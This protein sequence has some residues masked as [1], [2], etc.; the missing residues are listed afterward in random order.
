MSQKGE[1]RGGSG[2]SRTP[3]RS[4]LPPQ[5]ATPYSQTPCTKPRQR[6]AP[7]RPGS[8][9]GPWPPPR[10]CANW[11]CA[12]TSAAESSGR[13][14]APLR[15]LAA[16]RCPCRLLRRRRHGIGA[17]PCVAAVTGTGR[18]HRAS[19]GRARAKARLKLRLLHH[20]RLQLHL[21]VRGLLFPRP[22]PLLPPLVYHLKPGRLLR[23][24]R[25]KLW[26]PPATRYPAT[27]RPLPSLTSPKPLPVSR[28]PALLLP[29]SLT[30]QSVPPPPPMLEVSPLPN[31]TLLVLK[32]S[33]PLPVHGLIKR[34]NDTPNPDKSG[35]V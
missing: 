25:P 12:P 13:S 18:L 19:G 32:R 30:S 24:L 7:A 10:Q 28:P 23:A 5:A 4:P 11:T 16:G 31:P 34:C 15:A 35:T 22:R 9:G 27:R 17:L 6:P 26:P 20:I 3:S 33:A 2:R 14:R 8:P 1:P 29:Q 21:L